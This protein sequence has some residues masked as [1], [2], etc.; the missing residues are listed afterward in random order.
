M[1]LTE[2]NM[3]ISIQEIKLYIGYLVKKELIRSMHK[4][5]QGN[6]ERG[7]GQQSSDQST[8][9]TS[10]QVRKNSQDHILVQNFTHHKEVYDIRSE[11]VQILVPQRRLQ[12]STDQR[13][14]R[15]SS[16]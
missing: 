4:R 16:L 1:P 15:Q 10:R 12:T 5:P 7:L 6:L 3:A 2:N 14:K 13:H 9:H 11:E 8:I